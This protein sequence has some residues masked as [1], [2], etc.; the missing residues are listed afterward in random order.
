MPETNKPVAVRVEAR[1]IS[2]HAAP[3]SWLVTAGG[4]PLSE[5]ASGWM[6][7]LLKEVI[8][9]GRGPS[10]LNVE[11]FLESNPGLNDDS[12]ARR[13]A[14]RTGA[15]RPAMGL[16]VWPAR[17]PPRLPTR[18]DFENAGPTKPPRNDRYQ[19]VHVTG[20]QDIA[21]KACFQFCDLGNVVAAVTSD[22]RKGYFA[23]TAALLLPPI[24]EPSFRSAPFYVPLLEEA[25]FE[26]V[27]SE[28]TG[29]WMCGAALYLRQSLED[30]GVVVVSARPLGPVFEKLGMQRGSGEGRWN[31]VIE[32][33]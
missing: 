18:A 6:S 3:E 9:A 16:G 7:V 31:A 1:R 20:G 28:T 30:Q 2:E 4:F 10:A 33:Q 24:T 8:Q 27:S 13:L 21:L 32:P 15:W 11:V 5:P 25:S 22:D 29:A 23:R 26:K 17:E 12:F 14:Q 19:V